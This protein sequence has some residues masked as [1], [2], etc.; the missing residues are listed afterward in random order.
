MRFKFAAVAVA[1]PF[2]IFNTAA[3]ASGFALREAS[4]GAMGTAY[5]GAAATN[6]DPSYMFYN[7]AATAG[8]VD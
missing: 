2:V 6:S 7:P 3:H 5:A 1:A 8:V 4:T